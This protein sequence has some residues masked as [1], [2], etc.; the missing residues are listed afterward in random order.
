MDL[1]N[2]GFLSSRINIAAAP[3]NCNSATANWFFYTVLIDDAM[4]STKGGAV[5]I[6]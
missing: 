6:D 1:L 2:S 5:K 4:L 3:F